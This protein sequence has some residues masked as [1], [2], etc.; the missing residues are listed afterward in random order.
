VRS[1]L[2]AV[3]VM[4][5]GAVPLRGQAP[6]EVSFRILE[7]SA[8]IGDARVTIAKTESGWTVTGSSS[9][10]GGVRVDIRRF[11]LVYDAAWRGRSFSL[12]LAGG[13]RTVIAHGMVAVPGARSRTDVVLEQEVLPAFNH[14]SPHTV[15]LPDH[16]LPAFVALPPRLAGSGPGRELPAFVPLRTELTLAVEGV[17]TDTLRTATGAIAVRLWSLRLDDA[18]PVRIELWERAGDLLR[19][20]LPDAGLSMIRMDLD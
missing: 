19:V 13:G 18:Q 7:K 12:E 10:G 1:A 16:V 5:L 4:L 17:K 11:E 6:G 8:P 15:L 2:A 3:V 20:D 14:V 9:L